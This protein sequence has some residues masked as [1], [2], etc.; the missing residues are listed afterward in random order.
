M[1][2]HCI[3][4]KDQP[5]NELFQTCSMKASVLE[6]REGSINVA[7]EVL[8]SGYPVFPFCSLVN[9]ARLSRIR[10]TSAAL[11][12]TKASIP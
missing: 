12:S 7:P 9:S 4:E 1:N 6:P 2:R 3:I 8:F 11:V 5:E 10:D